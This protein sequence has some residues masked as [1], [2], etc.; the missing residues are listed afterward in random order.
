MAAEWYEKGLERVAR[1]WI[2]H[3]C[4]DDTCDLDGEACLA[5]V[6]TRTLERLLAAGQAMHDSNG[7]VGKEGWD[8][9]KKAFLKGCDVARKVPSSVSNATSESAAYEASVKEGCDGK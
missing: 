6:L 2:E 8:A 4:G 1:K 5:K 9:A 7:M 3:S